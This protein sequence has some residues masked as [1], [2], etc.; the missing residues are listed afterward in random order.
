MIIK[1]G[2]LIIRW[3]PSC[4][5]GLSLVRKCHCNC[6]QTEH[7]CKTKLFLSVGCVW[8]STHVISSASN[9]HP[10]DGSGRGLV[11]L[12]GQLGQQLH[13]GEVDLQNVTVV[14]FQVLLVMD[15][16]F[17]TPTPTAPGRSWSAKCDTHQIPGAASD[18]Q[19]FQNNLHPHPTCQPPPSHAAPWRNWSA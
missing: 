4:Y 12:G 14:R 1:S 15:W 13:Q 8:Q 19:G 9:R 17:A 6:N 3:W 5:Q 11:P 18:K 2:L 7:R 16:D 10:V